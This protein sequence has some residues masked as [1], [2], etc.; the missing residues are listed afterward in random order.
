MIGMPVPD[1]TARRNDGDRPLLLA[2]AVLGLTLLSADGG[3]MFS[4]LDALGP[5]G[6]EST[7]TDDGVGF[8]SDKTS[9]GT[10]LQGI[11]D[12]LS[13]LGGEVAVRS[14]PGAGTTVTGELPIVDAARGP[15]SRL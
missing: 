7:L 14:T 6:S 4:I 11:A 10:G 2:R 13:A 8:D 15:D 5:R 12:R 1:G 9:L 3:I